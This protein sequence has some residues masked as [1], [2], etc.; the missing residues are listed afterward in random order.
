[1]G[2]VWSVAGAG[3]VL[4]AGAVEPRGSLLSTPNWRCA[5]VSLRY[6]YFGLIRGTEISCIVVRKLCLAEFQRLPIWGY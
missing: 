4:G 6:W 2:F 1:M 5:L 3:G